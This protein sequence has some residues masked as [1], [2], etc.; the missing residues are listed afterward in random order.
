MSLDPTT[1]QPELLEQV[2]GGGLE[3]LEDMMMGADYFDEFGTRRPH[4]RTFHGY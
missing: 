1:W 4:G 2:V 3:D